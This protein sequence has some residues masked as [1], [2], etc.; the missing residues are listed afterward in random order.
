MRKP[1]TLL[2]GLVIVACSFAS[3]ETVTLA[4]TGSPTPT[5]K[6]VL[7][8]ATETV[9]TFSL[10]GFVRERETAE[11]VAYDR[12]KLEGRGTTEE[13]GFPELPAVHETVMIPGHRK[14]RVEVVKWEEVTL[15][16][17]KIWPFQTPAT[18]IDYEL[19]FVRNEGYY[20][21]AATYPAK[22][23]ELG[24]PAIF[25]DIR[26][27]PLS[28]YPFRWNAASEELTVATKITVKFRYYGQD[29]VNTLNVTGYRDADF[30]PLYRS[31]VINYKPGLRS[32][33]G[34]NLEYPEILFI[35]Y[36]DYKDE[37]EPLAEFYNKMGVY[38]VVVTTNETGTTKESIKNYIQQTYNK[39]SPAVLK[40]VLLVGDIDY[41]AAGYWPGYSMV[42]D[43]WYS[44][45]TGGQPDPYPDVNVGRF[46]TKDAAKV[47]YFVD[48]TIKYQKDPDLS[49]DWL[50]NAMLC[51]HYQGSPGKYEGCCE[52]VASYPYSK[53]K[54]NFIKI[55]GSQGKRNTDVS[56]TINAGV[57]I[58]SY[59]GHG[60]ATAW[61]G[62][63]YYNE[64]YTTGYV[65]GLANGDKTSVW[66]NICCLNGN[67][68]YGAECFIESNLNATGKAGVASNSA[69]DPSYTIPNHDYMKEM[70]KAIYDQ[71]I[72]NVGRVSNYGN[73]RLIQIYGPYSVYMKNVYMYMWNGDPFT[74]I[75]MKKPELQLKAIHETKFTP[76]PGRVF[77]V[78]VSDGTRGPVEGA[79]VGLY[80]K[81]DIYC[82][83]KTNSEGKTDLIPIPKVGTGGTMYVTV[84]KDGYLSY[85][86]ECTVEPTQDVKITNFAARRAEG[87]VRLSWSAQHDGEL[88]GF[89]LHRLEVRE[90]ASVD[91]F[92]GGGVAA[93]EEASWVKINDELIV[94]RGPYEYIDGVDEGKYRY[95]LEAVTR[96]DPIMVGPISIDVKVAPKA[97][98]LTQ[99]YPN[100]ANVSTNI[101]FGLPV[102][103]DNIKLNVYDLAGRQIKTFDVGTRSPGVETI[104][105]D[106]TDNAGRHVPAG[107]YIYRL[108][109]PKFSATKRM[110]VVR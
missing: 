83:G 23:V 10:S 73:T 59:R 2:A 42:A 103:T 89:N 5:A 12:I 6:V 53:F 60:S 57:N 62:W 102:T 72:L 81:D 91:S 41:V 104:T 11:G 50:N 88:V 75:W 101:S 45:L 61:T 17:Y 15:G 95:K 27:I 39:S 92:A 26:V 32:D 47:T 46:S 58:A 66:L 97:F 107:V 64:Y 108:D 14:A 38:T 4:G 3:A 74:K 44:C 36:P 35:C 109:T 25:R 43:Y 69:S 63:N 85:W 29:D 76:G 1:L 30:E 21:G 22:R 78:Q 93:A 34:G 71:G 79:L 9:I 24:T 105:W 77:L 86:G 49:N 68:A 37:A 7:D 8:T 33:G 55:Y 20:A 96:G 56:N 100:P 16:G 80:K 54:P 90:E 31:T 65:H 84:T 87:G 51:A 106:L 19:P 28:L 67:F 110:V 94:G 48:K 18:D 52:E 98:V 40:Y 13:I 70:Y 99:N 82:A